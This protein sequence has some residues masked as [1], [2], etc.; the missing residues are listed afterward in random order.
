MK[1]INNKTKKIKMIIILIL[2]TM[3]QTILN[4]S[5]LNNQLEE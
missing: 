5:I 3:I 1:Y 2:I 4:E